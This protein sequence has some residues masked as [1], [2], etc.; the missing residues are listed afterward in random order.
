M[1]NRILQPIEIG[2]RTLRNRIFISAH[3]PGFA[4]Q[5]A[6]GKRYISYHRQRAAAGVAMQITGGTAVHRS[7]LLTTAPSALVNLDDTIVPGYQ[8][9]SDAVQGEGGTILAQ[10]AHSAGTLSAELLG[11][12]S[13]APSP[14][15]SALTGNVPHEMSSAEISE[16]IDAF[17][18]ASS[19]VRAG[20][21]DG[22]ELLSA[23]GFLPHAFLSPLNNRRT[24]GYGGSLRNR[25]RFLLE[26][27][28]AC[29]AAIGKDRILGIR[30][31]G[32]DMVAGGLEISD[33]QTVAQALENTGQVDYLNVIAYNNSLRF[34]RALHWPATPAHHELFTELSSQIKAVVSLPVLV[35]GRITHP[36]QAEAVIANGQAD[37]VAMTRAHITD[38]EIV[39][40]IAEGRSDDIRPCVGANTCIR[41]R[42]Q[43]RPVRCMHNPYVINRNTDQTPSSSN[44]L[45]L[46]TVIG[47]GPA[48]LEAALTAAQRGHPVRL[49]ER[50]GD[51]GGQLRLW[52]R[53]ESQKELAAIIDWRVRQL[54]K[55][56]VRPEF[57][58]TVTADQLLNIDDGIIVMATG[59]EAV[60]DTIPGDGSVAQ[61]T[62]VELLNDPSLFTG[63]ALIRDQGRGL[64]ALC[65]AEALAARGSNVIVVTDEPAVGLDL[66]LTVRVPAYDRLLNCGVEFLPNH[67][68]AAFE[69]GAVKLRHVFTGQEMVLASIDVLVDD[70]IMRPCDELIKALAGSGRVVR[71]VGDC[72]APRTVEAAIHEAAQAITQL[73]Q[74]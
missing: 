74:A 35:A 29:R 62:P 47:A 26:L 11:Q 60:P 54:D 33:M 22:I 61:T 5:G 16:I 72:I 40:K 48:G 31:P 51:Y 68:L 50:S 53:V 17:V 43:G 8:L 27:V 44:N 49:L 64:S 73:T 1:H 18:A 13:W 63:R 12:P 25:M 70:H 45:P 32:S 69:Q 28:E 66:D 56:G 9:L 34:G 3:V 71:S 6:P 67:T 46:V 4:D 30:I 41:A 15:R 21:L 55:L 19:R 65:A 23:F 58:Q 38:P 20:G 10:L 42:F 36:D 37:M 59:A 57:N 39:R 14:V 52:S 24:D 2:P 7:G